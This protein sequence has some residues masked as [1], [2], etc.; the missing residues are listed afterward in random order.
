MQHVET[1][2][3]AR[4]RF[5]LESRARLRW[6]GIVL[7]L[8]LAGFAAGRLIRGST[9]REGSPEVTVARDMSAHDD[10]AVEMALILR[11]RTQDEALRA[12][13]R[14]HGDAAG[15]AGSDGGPARLLGRPLSKG[16]SMAGGAGTM[17]MARQQDVNRRQSLPIGPTEQLFLG[18]MIRRLQGGVA[19]A[20]QVLE[21]LRRPEA[22]RLSSTIV[23]SQASEITDLQHLLAQRNGAAPRQRPEP[24]PAEHGQHP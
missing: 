8:L 14:Y 20:Q 5:R 9:P 18:L 12:D 1:V 24:A 10:Q 7:I 6:A 13:A 17:G 2:Q 21:Q 15:A 22:A 4:S 23:R 16:T 19:V 11:D 3:P